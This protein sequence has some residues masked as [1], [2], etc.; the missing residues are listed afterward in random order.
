VFYFYVLFSTYGEWGILNANA[1]S[2][3]QVRE[4]HMKTLKNIFSVVLTIAL[5]ATLTGCNRDKAG[6]VGDAERPQVIA[7]LFPVYDFVREIGADRVD[8]TLLL[9]PGVEP[10]SFDPT[11]RDM[12]DIQNAAMFIYTG[13]YMEPWA[14]KIIAGTQGKTVVI[15][16][17]SQGI[18]LLGESDRDHDDDQEGLH[19]EGKDPHIWLDPVYAQKMVDNIVRG[20]VEADPANSG[21]YRESGIAYKHKLHELDD[22]FVQTFQRVEHKTIIYGGHFAFGYFVK[23]YGL[24]HVSPYSGFAPNA[25]PTPQKIVELVKNIA[26]SDVKVIYFEELVDPKVAKVIADETGAQMLLLHGAHNVSREELNAGISYLEIMEGN[27]AR[28]KEGLGY[29]D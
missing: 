21:F 19:H 9:P 16:D 1:N 7:T 17:A 22:K 26:E 18:E 23:R 27:L 3:Q 10:H 20:L 24:T 6:L 29:H 4:G 14:H 15:V 28:L 13:E 5:L 2:L 8:V 11:P 12:A 25:E